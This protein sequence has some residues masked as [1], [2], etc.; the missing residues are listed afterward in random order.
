LF[1]LSLLFS[2]CLSSFSCP[3]LFSAL[4]PHADL[5]EEADVGGFKIITDHGHALRRVAFSCLCTLLEIVPHRL[6]MKD[7][8]KNLM[9]AVVANYTKDKLMHYELQTQG[10]DLFRKN[11]ATTH[12]T[13]LLELLNSMP[14]FIIEVAKVNV[15]VAKKKVDKSTV[16]DPGADPAKAQEVLRHMVQAFMVMKTIPGAEQLQQFTQFFGIIE[17]TGILKDYLIEYTKTG[18]PQ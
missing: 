4:K 5:I 6:H 1:L 9:E 7:F 2:F 14:E 3:C 12:Q 11:L 13:Y 16:V 18:I 10:W 17:N 15:N 8:I